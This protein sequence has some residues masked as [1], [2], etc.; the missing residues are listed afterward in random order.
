[1]DLRNLDGICWIVFDAAK[2]WHF[3]H[4]NQPPQPYLT[5]FGFSLQI[6]KSSVD[7]FKCTRVI[8]G[9]SAAVLLASHAK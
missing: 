1:V 3:T 7:A 4:N 6:C 2:F 8:Y 5:S 9:G